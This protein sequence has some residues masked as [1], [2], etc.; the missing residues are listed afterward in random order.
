MRCVL[1]LDIYKE[2]LTN[3]MENENYQMFS[4]QAQY[5]SQQKKS[6]KIQQIELIYKCGVKKFG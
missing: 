4:A 6:K 3:T 5:M 1:V 2:S